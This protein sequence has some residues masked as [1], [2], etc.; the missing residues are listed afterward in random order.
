MSRTNTRITVD[1]PTVD[2]KKLKMIAA[3]HGKSMRD[4]F[5]ELIEQGLERY[6]ECA[7]DHTPNE[8]TKKAI[9]SFKTK[10]GVQR[11]DT[12]AELFEKLRK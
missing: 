5:V 7:K 6:E 8:V 3:Y 4:I 11:A 10:R 2:H 12:V 9:E 1:I